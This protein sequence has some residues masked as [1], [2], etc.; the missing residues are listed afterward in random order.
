MLAVRL[1]SHPWVGDFDG[2]VKAAIPVMTDTAAPIPTSTQ[3]KNAHV[4][5]L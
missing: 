4:F 5:Y 3:A 2:V 1:L